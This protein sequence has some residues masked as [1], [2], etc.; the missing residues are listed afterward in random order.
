MKLNKL[1]KVI[2]L[3]T[4]VAVYTPMGIRRSVLEELSYGFLKD[5]GDYQVKDIEQENDYLKILLGDYYG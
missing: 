1:L 4:K 2:S 3:K 5:W